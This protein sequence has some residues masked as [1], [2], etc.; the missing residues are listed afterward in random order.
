MILEDRFPQPSYYICHQNSGQ[1]RYL[2]SK[3]NP[4]Q[5]ANSASDTGTSNYITDDASLKV[6]MDYL[7]KLVVQTP[8]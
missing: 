6:F 5:S 8:K 3:V 7:V 4:S 1:E 2:K